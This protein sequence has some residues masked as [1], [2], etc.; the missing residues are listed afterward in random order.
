MGNAFFPTVC[1]S[2]EDQTGWR[3]MSSLLVTPAWPWA[4]VTQRDVCALAALRVACCTPARQVMSESLS[5]NAAAPSG[6]VC[7][8]F[9]SISCPAPVGNSGGDGR[10]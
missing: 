8:A 2:F 4:R 7:C 6:V 10:C 9:P 1:G 3:T 5:D